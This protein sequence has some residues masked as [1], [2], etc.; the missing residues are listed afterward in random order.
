MS[1]DWDVSDIKDYKN[2]CYRPGEDGKNHLNPVT[3]HLIWHTISA[4]MGTITRENIHE[5]FVRI[6]AAEG[7][8]GEGP[9]TQ[10]SD[11]EK[12]IGLKT[13]V[14]PKETTKKWIN[15]FIQD[16]KRGYP[17]QEETDG[18]NDS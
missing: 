15:R 11:V 1:L 6:R 18:N 17:L 8:N 12:H 13:N 14:F 10:F 3:N 7:Y 5:F 16:A 9:H 2:V 4:G